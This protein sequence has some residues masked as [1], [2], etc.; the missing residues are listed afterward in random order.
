MSAIPSYKDIVD[1]IKKGATL[2]AQERV[3]ELREAAISLQDENH[4]ILFSSHIT[5]DLEKIAD[6]IAFIH[7]GKIVFEHSKDELLYNYGIIKCGKNELSELDKNDIIRIKKDQLGCE[8]LVADK[9]AA[10]RKYPNLLIDST[11][12][13]EIMLLYVKGE[14]VC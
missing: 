1:L 5:N 9:D 8:A 10:K 3:M 14:K 12:I 7:N 6:Y 11:S 4:S 13:D 2:E